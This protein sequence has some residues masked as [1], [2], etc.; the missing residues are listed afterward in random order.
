[1]K[2]LLG[3]VLCAAFGLT[4]APPALSAGDKPADKKPADKAAD[5]ALEGYWLGTLNVGGIG[6]R[7]GVKFARQK[8]G[9][10][11]ATLDSIDQGVKGIPVEAFTLK[12]GVLHLEAKSIKGTYEGKLKEG[13]KEVVGRWKQGPVD[14]PLTLKHHDREPPVRRPQVP[15]KP[16]PY[17]EE[18]VTY[19]NAKAKVKFAGTLTLPK[20][21]GPFPAVLLITGSGAQDRD[22]SLMGHK[23]FLVLADHLTRRGIAV[24]RVDDR[25]VGGSTG[26]T[27]KS[28][29]ADFAG[30][31]LAGVVYLRTRQEI[32]PKQ[33][34]L[35]GHSEGGVVAPL[36]ASQSKDVAFIVLLAGTGLVGEEILYLQGDLIMR[37]AGADEKARARQ[38]RLQ[39][40]LVG[41]AKE[42]KD[43][44][45]AREKA[46]KIFAEE[47]AKASEEEQK[48]LRKAEGALEAQVGMI[49][50]P[51]FRYFVT[52]DPLPALRKV[53]C[54]VLALC[55]EKDLQVPPR[56]NLKAI[57]MA[58]AEGGNQDYTIK[59]FPKLNH[60][61]Q[62]CRTGALSEYGLIEETIA[63]V[64]LDFVSEWI[65]RR[66]TA[67]GK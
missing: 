66:T 38:K 6:L 23:P 13:G 37:A 62:T 5:K 21:A 55:G 24:L 47:V 31:A 19:E 42:E 50:T 2:A 46:K 44:K 25:G 34:G 17:A 48:E 26:D 29:T 18:E 16:Y 8:D 27:M 33:I 54:P 40:L 22:E 20:G 65:L 59:E 51:W 36:A 30:D 67:A 57:G 41:L 49:L 56:Q 11:R 64:V 4:A 3:V 14:L 7:L 58:L 1:M 52:H 35:M 63:P 45:A 12:D 32:N 15:K 28:T 10:L 61:F 43:D 60:L 9:A 53:R 39:R